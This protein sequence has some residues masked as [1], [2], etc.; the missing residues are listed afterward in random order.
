M[1]L[2][3][4]IIISIIIFIFLIPACRIETAAER[5]EAEEIFYEEDLPVSRPS[6]QI[7][8]TLNIPGQA[9]DLKIEDNYVYMTNDLGYLYVIDVSVKEEPK[10]L[11]KARG[12]SSANIVIISEGYCYIS[13]TDLEFQEGSAHTYYGF[14]ILDISDKSEPTV[15]SDYRLESPGAEAILYGLYVEKNYAYITIYNMRQDTSIFEIIDVADKRN[16]K[17]EG[18]FESEGSLIGIMTEKDHAYMVAS[19][20]SERSKLIC[21]DISNKQDPLFLSS[22]EVPKG[23]NSVYVKEERAYIS[24]SQYQPEK[25][26][27]EDS[28]VQAID[29]ADQENMQPLG[30]VDL[31]GGAWEMDYIDGYLYV[32]NLEGGLDVIDV[33]DGKGL[34]I[35]DSLKTNGTSYDIALKGGYGYLADGFEG[36]IILKLESDSKEPTKFADGENRKPKA[37]VEMHSNSISDHIFLLKNPVFFSASKSFDPDGD[38]LSYQWEIK[39]VGDYFA[40]FS[41]SKEKGSAIFIEEGA[42]EVVLTVSDGSVSDSISAAFEIKKHSIPFISIKEHTLDTEI[43]FSIHNL[44]EIELTDLYCFVKVPQSFYPYY[45]IKDIKTNALSEEVLFDKDFNKI[46]KLGFDNLE[47]NKE[48]S[49]AITCS[50]TMHEYR[51]EDLD[52]DNLFY[53]KTDPDY[54]KYT[55]EDLYIDSASKIIIDTANSI[56][57][58]ETNP[59]KIAEKIYDYTVKRLRYDFRRAE[60]PGYEYYYASEILKNRTGVCSDYSI[61]YTALLRAAGIPSRIAFGIPVTITANEPNQESNIGHAWVEIKLPSYGWVP[62]DITPEDGFMKEDYYLNLATEKGNSFFH[63]SVTMDWSSYY[64]DGFSYS[65]DAEDAPQVEQSINYRIIGLDLKDLWA[66]D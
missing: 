49:A 37:F 33:S 22:C 46:L 14:K 39:N 38:K 26:R 31:K 10:I 35:I 11:S 32:S 29:I 59:Y 54:V 55:S 6:A 15:I 7:I 1:K 18:S 19:D 43:I 61:L 23:A 36:L 45:E 40:E 9:I 64:Y 65:W 34:Q 25:D 30:S 60:D 27:Y 24:S 28:F 13:Y 2:K 62:I 12:I 66:F 56:V 21:L 17:L 63:K 47:P 41:A 50:V 51:Y 3:I 8:S 53:D 42:Y 48:L 57:G 4:T 16:P 44:S 5:D 20:E 52:I 58:R